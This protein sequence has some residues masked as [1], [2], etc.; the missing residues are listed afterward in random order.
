MKRKSVYILMAAAMTLIVGMSVLARPK[1]RLPAKPRN[2]IAVVKSR[3]DDVDKVLTTFR[4]PHDILSFRDLETP[5]KIERYRSLFVPSGIDHP[6]EEMLDVYAN[7]FR[8]KSVALKP[9]FYEVDKDRVARTLR[10]FVRKGGSAYFSGYTYE[11]LQKAFDMLEYFNN[12]PYMGMPARIEATVFNDLS[13]FSASKRMALYMDHPGWIAIKEARNAEVVAFATFE[14]PRGIRSGPITFLARRGSGELLYT[15]YDSTVFSDFRR[16]NIYRIAGAHIMER[17]E[18]EA[19]RWG[20]AV[21]GRIVNAI[22]DY[23]YAE[24]HRIDL[25]NGNNT[26]YFFSEKEFYQ[27]DIVDS[28]LS[29]IESRDLLQREQ[30]FTVKSAGNDY[31]YIRLYPYGNERFGMYGIVSASG[32]RIIPYLYYIL[33]VLGVAAAGGLAFVVYR[34][35]FS[36]GYSGRGRL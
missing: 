27:I 26:I 14:T 18:D 7:N 25:A 20:Q 4:I 10:R 16:F 15:S 31:C 19:R 11:F 12:F 36:R 6:I 17:L 29:L 3:Y 24:T 2:R 32:R 22:H 13:R 28:H 1:M 33:G 5:E 21:T 30:V 8:F 34:L 23:E 9:D 35:F